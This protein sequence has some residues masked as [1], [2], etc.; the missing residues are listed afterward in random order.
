MWVD[1]LVMTYWK[2][3]KISNNYFRPSRLYVILLK[4]FWR[5]AYKVCL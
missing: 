4:P 2:L 5:M 3:N 1:L